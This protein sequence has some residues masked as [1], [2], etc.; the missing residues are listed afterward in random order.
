MTVTAQKPRAPPNKGRFCGRLAL[1]LARRGRT[2]Y[3]QPG[4]RPPAPPPDGPR[5]LAG[6]AAGDRLVRRPGRERGAM[7]EGGRGHRAM[8]VRCGAR[9]GGGALAVGPRAAA[10]DRAPSP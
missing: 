9:L 4:P 8:Q 1:R 6:R 5:A 3:P 7:G 2:P 10:A